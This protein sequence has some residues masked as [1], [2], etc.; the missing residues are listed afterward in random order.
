MRCSGRSG[1]LQCRVCTG[2]HAPTALPSWA[3]ASFIL[4]PRRSPL[5]PLHTK[6]QSSPGSTERCLCHRNPNQP[7]QNC[8]D[9]PRNG[10][11]CN[12]SVLVT[13]PGVGQDHGGRQGWQLALPTEPCLAS[14]SLPVYL[15][16]NSLKPNRVNSP[17][18]VLVR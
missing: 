16:Y 9:P 15:F 14:P 12:V 11:S 1:D 4:L 6:P 8:C 5:C 18:C 3:W 7:R 13:C 2:D 17:P 10:C